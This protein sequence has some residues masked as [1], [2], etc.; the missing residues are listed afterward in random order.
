MWRWWR[1][2]S[3][4]PKGDYPQRADWSAPYG[5]GV[6]LS[7]YV[8][9]D[10]NRDGVLDVGDLPMALVVV[11]VTR[12]DGKIFTVR[13]NDSGFA[14]FEMSRT[15]RNAVLRKPGDYVFSVHVPP[16]WVLTTGNASQRTTLE[17]LPGAPADMVSRN[18]PRPFGL[19]PVLTIGGRVAVRGKA[20]AA[21]SPEGITLSAR[22]PGGRTVD[23]PLAPGGAFEISAEPGP[24][25]LI[26][27]AAGS[28]PSIERALVVRDA[29]VRLSTIVLGDPAVEPSGRRFTIDF[30]SM[31]GTQI[32]KIP[33]GVAG[34]N[35][36]YLNVIDANTGGDAYTNNV[37]SGH[38]VGYGSSGHPVTISRAGGFDFL[39]ASFGLGSREGEGDTL[40][41]QAFRGDTAVAEDEL[42]LSSLGP[43]RFDAEFR[44]IDRL[45]LT[46]RHYWQLVVD[47]MEVCVPGGD[48][49]PAPGAPAHP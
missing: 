20:G 11:T 34:L 39:G 45:V 2:R 37:T 48:A 33:S 8:F 4:Q 26:A 10:R 21:T 23:V 43:V 49:V 12:P 5:G 35:W 25:T 9:R 17:D 31:T 16:G 22:S 14:N 6:H 40:R 15:E 32:A 13:S 28:G 24:W 47:D 29:P 46:T 19:A 27:R 42:R 18:P 41:V 44:R 3:S 1:F 38:Y 7:G 30:E 36:D